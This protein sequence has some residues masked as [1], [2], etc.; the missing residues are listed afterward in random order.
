MGRTTVIHRSARVASSGAVPSRR[1]AAPSAA[2]L[3]L[4]CSKPSVAELHNVAGC[5]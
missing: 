4:T 5:A 2:L 1:H 3:T